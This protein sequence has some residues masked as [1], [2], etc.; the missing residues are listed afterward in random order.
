MRVTRKSIN[1]KDDILLICTFLFFSP[2]LFRKDGMEK[3]N[4][5]V[6]TKHRSDT[7]SNFLAYSTSFSCFFV[8]QKCLLTTLLFPFALTS[9]RLFI[10]NTVTCLEQFLDVICPKT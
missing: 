7:Y 4:V 8:P 5:S 3:R 1:V 6:M 2:V 10:T 9:Q